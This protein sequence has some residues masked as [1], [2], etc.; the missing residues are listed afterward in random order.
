M[1]LNTFLSFIS[2]ALAGL[3]GYYAFNI[4]EGKENDII[5]GI[6]SAICFIA[7]LLPAIGLQYKTTRLSINMRN[8]SSIFFIVFL[9]SHFC[10]AV[11]GVNLP[12]Y[13]IGNGILLVIYLALFY[14][15][16]RIKDI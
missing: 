10:F 7:T 6:G 15:M 3:I 9:I 5:C 12:Y 11:F 4:A 14:I 16:Q 2:I 1:K 8:L 13:V